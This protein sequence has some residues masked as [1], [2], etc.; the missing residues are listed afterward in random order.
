MLSSSRSPARQPFASTARTSGPRGLAASACRGAATRSAPGT[1]SPRFPASRSSVPRSSAPAAGVTAAA[2]ARAG[3][4]RPGCIRLDSCRMLDAPLRGLFLWLAH[5]RWVARLSLHTPFVRRVALRFVAGTDLE[6]AVEA[7]RVLNG[8]GMSATLDHLGES[9]TDRAT[10][11]RAAA[12]Y[13]ATIE[14]IDAEHLDTNVSLK[15]TQMGLD[16][17]TDLC[18]EV[19]RPVAEASRAHGIFVRV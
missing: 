13:V 2:D 16:L 11:E 12:A 3:R 6:Q 17:G 9:V 10:A 5:R 14:R 18:L 1:P 19:L 8:S 4:H 15:L 7:V